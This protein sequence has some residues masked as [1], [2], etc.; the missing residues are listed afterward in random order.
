MQP[1]IF[2]RAE[3]GA[4]LARLTAALD[5]YDLSAAT[6]ALTGLKSAGLPQWGAVD[7]DKLGASIENYDYD[8]ARAVATRLLGRVNSVDA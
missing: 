2:D 5:A 6:T 4:A 8:E 3:A 7:L 1:A